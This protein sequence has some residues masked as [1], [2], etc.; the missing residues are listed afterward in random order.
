MNRRE[1][2]SGSHLAGSACR[3]NWI[4]SPIVGDQA[5]PAVV[6]TWRPDRYTA[7]GLPTEGGQMAL[8]EHAAGMAF[9]GVVG[10]DGAQGTRLAF[11]RKRMTVG[12]VN[13][14]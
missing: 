9:P 2:R 8:R 14:L 5:S 11:S 4:D 12:M 6:L 1:R 10:R 13:L 7:S 3:G